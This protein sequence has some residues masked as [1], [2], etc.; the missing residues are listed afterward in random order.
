M[1]S[2]E[3]RIPYLPTR[4]EGL[5]RLAT[6]LWWSW[7]PEARSLFATIDPRLWHHIR[8]NPLLLLQ[9]IDPARIA[10]CAS[11]SALLQRYDEV[12]ATFQRHLTTDDTWLAHNR[13]E[14]AGRPIAYFCAEFGLHNSVPI[15]SGGLGVLAGDHLKSASDMG[16]PIVGVGLFYTNGYFDQKV[17]LDGWQT[18]SD[19][20]FDLAGTPIQPLSVP[21][22]EEWVTVVETSGRPV[23]VRAWKMMV[24]RVPVYLL[25]TNLEVNAPEDR[26]LMNKLYAGGPQLRIRQ[27]WI[28]GVGGVRVLRAV[29]IDPAVWHANEG[30][31]RSCSW[32]G[33]GTGPGRHLLRG[34]RRPCAH[35]VFTTHTPVPAGHDFFELEEL[36]KVAG[37][38]GSR[39]GWTTSNSSRWAR[40]RVTRRTSHDGGAVRLAA[41]VNGVSRPHGQVSAP[42]AQPVARPPMGSGADRPRHQRRPL[43]HLDGRTIQALLT[44]HL[45]VRWTD[46]LDDSAWTGCLAR[47]RGSGGA[48]RPQGGPA[49]LHREDAR[50][51]FAGQL[52]EAAAVVGAGTL[53]DPDVLT[54]GFARRFATY[55]RANLIFSDI[56]RLRRLCTNPDRPVQVIFAGKAHPADAPGKE[57]LQSVYRYTRDPSFEGR[58]AFVEDYDMHIAHLLVQGVDTWLNLPR[59]PLEASGTSGMKA[60]LNG[61][62]QLST[63]DGWWQEGYDGL[64]GW[65]IPTGS[66][67]SS[68]DAQDAESCYRLLEEQVVPLYYTRDSRDIPLGWVERMRHALRL[69]GRRFTAH[70]MLADYVREYYLPASRADLAGDAPPTD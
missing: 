36:V 57:V 9:Q 53:F 25:D 65:A 7:S 54:I 33:C 62:P 39:S 61:V 14:L 29:G 4:I 41:R 55:K 27:E 46:R 43:A 63:L 48:P 11:D 69:G 59:V 45:G 17:N 8:H 20:V 26:A 56:D 32:S 23:H 24:G 31:R 3:Q 64:G 2:L 12:M 18:D 51:R 22:G 60:A 35:A 58:I 34:R 13:P 30:T 42:L 15:Y 10:A 68:S 5:S 67:G 40:C 19:E 38:Y 44:E 66:N 70:R 50:H 6:N 21:S 37:P 16:V 52:K 47:P 1:T 28:L 49:R